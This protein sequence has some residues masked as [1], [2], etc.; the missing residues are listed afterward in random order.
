MN[1]LQELDNEIQ[2]TQQQIKSQ[3]DIVGGVGLTQID[4]HASHYV[5]TLENRLQTV[6]LVIMLLSN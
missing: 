3:Q 5:K 6:C 1:R 2:D 4:I